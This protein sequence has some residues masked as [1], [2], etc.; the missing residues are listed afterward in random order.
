MYISCER[1][2][3]T[4]HEL[5]HNQ[6]HTYVLRVCVRTL[7]VMLLSLLPLPPLLYRPLVRG[8]KVTLENRGEVEASYSLVKPDTLFGP[9]F[10]FTP[11]EG[12]LQ[13]GGL[14]A[15]EVSSLGRV[16]EC[17]Q[18][19]TRSRYTRGM[20][21]HVLGSKS[22]HIE[23]FVCIHSYVHAYTI[24]AVMYALHCVCLSVC[25]SVCVLDLLLV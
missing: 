2:M 16:P 18:S 17:Q 5:P 3:G 20:C 21:G 7:N 8:V 23:V 4:A 13:P 14:Q 1:P 19:T 22:M 15:I 9:K 11:H 10:T 24:G 25:V 6:P 12:I